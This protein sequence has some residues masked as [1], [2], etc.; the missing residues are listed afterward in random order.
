MAVYSLNMS[1]VYFKLSINTFS[2]GHV[3]NVLYICNTVYFQEPKLVT[4]FLAKYKVKIEF[5]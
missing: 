2:F 4:A 5:A 3:T 1:S